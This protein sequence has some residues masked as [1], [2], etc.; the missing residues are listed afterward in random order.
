MCQER[1]P[2]GT[3]QSEQNRHTSCHCRIVW[4]HFQLQERKSLR[5]LIAQWTVACSRNALLLVKFPCLFVMN[6]QPEFLL[7]WMANCNRS[8][9]DSQIWPVSQNSC[10]NISFL[11]GAYILTL[12]FHLSVSNVIA[13]SH[14]YVKGMILLFFSL[15]QTD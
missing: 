7:F 4:A 13:F 8:M 11:S 3:H 10:I 6:K 9:S 14:Y 15:K 1:P 12:N 5:S 2:C